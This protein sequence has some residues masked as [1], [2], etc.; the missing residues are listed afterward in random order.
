M[1]ILRFAFGAARRLAVSHRRTPTLG[2]AFGSAQPTSLTPLSVMRYAF[3]AALAGLAGCAPAPDAA[4]VGAVAA[5]AAPAS[6]PAPIPAPQ[7]A[8]PAPQ[9]PA[10]ALPYRAELTR[11]ARALWGLDAPV[12]VFAAQVHTE[13]GWRADAVSPVGALGLAQFMPGTA[14][15]ISSIDP[16]LAAAQPYNPAWALRALVRYDQYLYSQAPA[17]YAPHDR[18]WVALR[19]YN[20]GLGHWINEARATGQPQ[21]TRAQ[22]DAA[23]GRASRAPKH[24]TENLAYPRRVL[25]ETQP[26][27]AAWGPAL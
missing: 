18:M 21:P 10:A 1:L 23:C 25:V 24:C 13:S 11:N 16:Q 4:P 6:M 27:Y 20:G 14:K 15:W 2:I 9:P 17:R 7:P 3:G 19:G 22:V 8:K 12:P 26:R 5:P